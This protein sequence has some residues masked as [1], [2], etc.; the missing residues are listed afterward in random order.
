M[1]VQLTITLPAE[2]VESV[3]RAVAEG[4]AASESDYIADSIAMRER[5]ENL[6]DA[7]AEWDPAST[8][9]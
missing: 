9:T 5:L 7:L 4:R 2:V 6:Q 3:R 1:T 8:Q